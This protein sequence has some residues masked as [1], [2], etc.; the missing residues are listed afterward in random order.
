MSAERWQR[1]A[2]DLAAIGHKPTVIEKNWAESRYGKIHFGTSRS[3]ILHRAGTGTVE[4]ADQY[5][6]ADRW[7]GWIVIASDAD[8]LIQHQT[9][10]SKKRGDVTKAVL[11]AM[12]D[13]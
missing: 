10:P 6:R 3:I 12:S 9:F 7:I 4:V 8:D 1:L 2:D 5:T 11:R 13:V